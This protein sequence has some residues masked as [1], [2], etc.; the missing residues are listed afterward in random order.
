[1]AMVMTSNRDALLAMTTRDGRP[2]TACDG[3]LPPLTG[4]EL[5][6]MRMDS[7]EA[8][9]RILESALSEL[10]RATSAAYSTGGQPAAMLIWHDGVL[11][12]TRCAIYHNRVLAREEALE[13][14]REY[15]WVFAVPEDVERIRQELAGAEG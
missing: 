9:V 3:E 15:R 1:M 2:Y 7:I 6:A 4:P 11:R 8:R 10:S 13:H 5:V 14:L 12:V